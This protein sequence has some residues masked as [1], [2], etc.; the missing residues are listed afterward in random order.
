MRKSAKRSRFSRRTWPPSPHAVQAREDR[1]V[2]AHGV[3]EALHEAA[4][5]G[6]AAE[7][8]RTQE[9]LCTGELGP[10]PFRRGF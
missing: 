4:N 6:L 7:E 5:D 2:A 1:L 10:R 9:E 8:A 3:V